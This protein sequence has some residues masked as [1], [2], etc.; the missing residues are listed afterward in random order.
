ME[1]ITDRLN[2]LTSNVPLPDWMRDKLQQMLSQHRQQQSLITRLNEDVITR[3]DHIDALRTQVNTLQTKLVKAEQ[4]VGRP[5]KLESLLNQVPTPQNQRPY[6]PALS[7]KRLARP[8]KV[9]TMRLLRCPRCSACRSRGI[10]NGAG[11]AQRRKG[12]L[13]GPNQ[14]V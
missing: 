1:F 9:M 5:K 4:F 10:E 6:R 13:R 8:L 3:Q 14:R 11:H 7:S 2:L 12:P